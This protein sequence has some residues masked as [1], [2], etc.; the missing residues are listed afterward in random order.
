MI[1]KPLRK[2]TSVLFAIFIFVVSV[3]LCQAGLFGRDNSQIN[4]R[5]IVGAVVPGTSFGGSNDVGPFQSDDLSWTAR[6][7]WARVYL[8]R[9]LIRF[10]VKGLVL[11]SQPNPAVAGVVIGAPSP[12]AGLVKGTLLCNADTTGTPHFDTDPVPLS[13]QGEA[14]FSGNV[15][16]LPANCPNAAFLIRISGGTLDGLWIAAGMTRKP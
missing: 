11:A 3:P 15:A 2:R 10:Q 4:W 13:P 1:F 6:R 12:A 5:R 14:S 7:G 8:K 16:G 9:D